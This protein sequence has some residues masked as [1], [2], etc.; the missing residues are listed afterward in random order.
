MFGGVAAADS[1]EPRAEVFFETNSSELDGVDRALLDEV[2]DLAKRCPDAKLILDGHADRTGSAEYNLSLAIQRAE[3]V[4]D[5]L[6]SEGV[7]ANRIVMAIYGEGG[8][9]RDTLE[10]D[11][12]VG[13]ELT[14]EPLNQ[15]AKR[16]FPEGTAVI[17]S[18]P[19]VV[20]EIEG[21]PAEE[22]STR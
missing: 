4:R 10:E 18:G 11:R 20:S 1:A 21:P 5:H 6:I 2:A 13:V 12:R 7:D 15:I 3:Q 22:I 9:P 14:Q 8:P 17:W 19:T 16:T